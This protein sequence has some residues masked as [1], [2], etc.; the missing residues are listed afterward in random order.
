MTV[1]SMLG[2]GVT[3]PYQ[4]VWLSVKKAPS[5]LRQTTHVGTGRLKH[6]LSMLIAVTI[7]ERKRMTLR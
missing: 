4:C 6:T 5:A 7:A 3:V 2:V 1:C